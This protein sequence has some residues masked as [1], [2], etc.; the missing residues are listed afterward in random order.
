MAKNQRKPEI[1]QRSDVQLSQEVLK[2]SQELQKLQEK[3]ISK[4][5]IFKKPQKPQMNCLGQ[6]I[7]F[8]G[9]ILHSYSSRVS[10]KT[11]DI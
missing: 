8:H 9:Y 2:A 6:L 10:E 5:I 4:R 3:R 7:T 1:R 11:R